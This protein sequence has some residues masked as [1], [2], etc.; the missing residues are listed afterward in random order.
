MN[1]PNR[2]TLLRVILV[3]VMIIISVIPYLNDNF[4]GSTSLTLAN[5]INLIIFCVASSTDFLDGYLARKNNQVTTFGKFADPL[6]DKML[7]IT[8]LLLLMSDYLSNSSASDFRAIVPAWAVAIIIIRELM[9]SGI[10]LVAAERGVVIAAGWS[11]KVKTAFTMITLILCFLCGAF[12]ANWYV[13][14]CT[15]ML[16]I[17]VILTIYSGAVYLIRSRKLIFE[18]I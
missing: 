9:V 6:A 5:L 14:L 1:M 8:S 15:V 11:G 3:P 7:V 10:R 2:L 13:I 17:S 12:E 18:S 4:V 16:Y